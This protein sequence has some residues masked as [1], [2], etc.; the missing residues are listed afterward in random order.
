V[1]RGNWTGL[2]RKGV[3]SHRSGTIMDE[4]EFKYIVER[5]KEAQASGETDTKLGR[6][7]AKWKGIDTPIH[8][9]G[10]W[11][12]EGFI[13]TFKRELEILNAN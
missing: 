1:K 4:A 3:E 2:G 5:I 10:K 8:R 9:D 12:L 7:L 13:M 6:V 11:L